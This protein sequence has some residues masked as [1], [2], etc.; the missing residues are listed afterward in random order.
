MSGDATPLDGNGTPAPGAGIAAGG[1]A[2]LAKEDTNRDGAVNAADA[3]FRALR[4]WRDLNQD[5]VSRAGESFTPGS[6]NITGINVA[7]TG[8][9]GE[10]SANTPP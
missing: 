10:T 3:R 5:G 2:A 8:V 6:Q 7:G 1:L 9:S 4:L